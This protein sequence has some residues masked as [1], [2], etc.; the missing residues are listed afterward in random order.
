MDWVLSEHSDY[1]YYLFCEIVIHIPWF[2]SCNTSDKAP[3]LLVNLNCY[4]GTLKQKGCQSILCITLHEKKSSQKARIL[5]VN[6]GINYL[7]MNSKKTHK[8]VE[9]DRKE[10]K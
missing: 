10:I 1:P 8:F 7:Y 3:F 9:K 6:F 4:L 5:T 2:L